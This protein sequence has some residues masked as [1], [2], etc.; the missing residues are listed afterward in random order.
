LCEGTIIL[1]MVCNAEARLIKCK[2]VDGQFDVYKLH[3]LVLYLDHIFELF[4]TLP[5][6]V[7]KAKEDILSVCIGADSWEGWKEIPVT[8]NYS[9]TASSVRFVND[10]STS[11]SINNI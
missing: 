11:I 5:K 1:Q 3:Q 7:E 2:I 6:T 9:R 8:F 10:G 4:Q